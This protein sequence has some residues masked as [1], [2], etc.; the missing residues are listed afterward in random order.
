MGFYSRFGYD[1]IVGFMIEI[2]R[3]V[4]FLLELCEIIKYDI[5]PVPTW[6]DVPH[7]EMNI[8][9]MKVNPVVNRRYIRT[10]G[11]SL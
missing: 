7:H 4:R 6:R 10:T 3:T 8:K 2:E 1:S 11:S 9:Q 5:T